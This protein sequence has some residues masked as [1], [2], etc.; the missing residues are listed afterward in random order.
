M[1]I[2]IKDGMVMQR[3]ADNSC[4]VT[5]FSELQLT[6]A[7]YYGA[8][9][10]KTAL[11]E[12][13]ESAGAAASAAAEEKYGYL[14]RGIPVGGPYTVE[15]LSADGMHTA[16]EHIYVGDV[17]ILAGQSNMEGVGIF[18]PQDFAEPRD[19]HI[20]ALFMTD[21]WGPARHPLH[22]LWQA[23]DA[24][25]HGVGRQQPNVGIGPGLAFARKMYALLGVPQGLLC[26]AHG[27]TDMGCWN[28][29][30]KIK[31][32][33]SFY[34]AMLRRYRANGSN[35][36]GM[37]WYQGCSDTHNEEQA[38][39]FT[40]RMKYF[41]ESCR[42][43][44]QQNLPI[45]QVQIARQAAPENAA[46]SAAWTQVREQQRQMPDLIPDLDTISAVAYRLD[47]G[48]HLCSESQQLTGENAA[49]SMYCLLY[50]SEPLRCGGI[51]PGM[52]LA[53]AALA[54]DR[55]RPWRTD[56]VLHFENVHGSLRAGSR[57][58]GF[59]LA[60]A[61]QHIM[62]N[63]IYDI[64]LEGSTIRVRTE[65]IPRETLETCFLYYGYGRNPDCNVTDEKGYALP[66][67]GPLCLK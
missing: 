19:P 65:G 30:L 67:F 7:E 17:W 26:C 32:S 15:L 31:G 4:A 62:P 24:V 16:F 59:A 1:M 45:V 37:F 33:A 6:G 41:V 48:I 39:A 3:G 18:T 46:E 66:A 11:L 23:V 14:L 29:D 20:R 22:E 38:A 21:V 50:R 36:R 12:P 35:V 57:A 47:D 13:A 44:M 25:H 63:A 5:L 60:D 54:A 55:I 61:Q 40:K 49:E 58:L 27:G 56:L 53:K 43:D 2:G 51:L 8:E 42:T 28:P 34:G 9:G 64:S 10:T 52:R